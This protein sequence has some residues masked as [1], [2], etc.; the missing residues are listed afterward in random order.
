MI[1]IPDNDRPE[2]TYEHVRALTE[3]QIT[4]EQAVR[5]ELDAIESDLTELWD[6]YYEIPYG[7]KYS[8]RIRSELPSHIERQLNNLFKHGDISAESNDKLI[9]VLTAMTIGIY[10]GDEQVHETDMAFWEND[11]NW[12]TRK[13]ESILTSYLRRLGEERQKIFSFLGA[14]PPENADNS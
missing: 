12:N 13:V 11:S 2:D 14:Q 1:H 5:D 10:I 9:N 4:S 7:S 8:I 3:E 6:D